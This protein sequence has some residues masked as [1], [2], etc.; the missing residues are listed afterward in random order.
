MASLL[1]LVGLIALLACLLLATSAPVSGQT[2]S[3]SVFFQTFPACSLAV[4]GQG[5]VYVALCD[6]TS[7]L[8]FNASFAPVSSSFD[9]QA[10]SVLSAAAANAPKPLYL[11]AMAVTASGLLWLLD[12]NNLQLLLLSSTSAA[13]G[14]T[15]FNLTA[16]L[17]GTKLAIAPGSDNVWVLLQGQTQPLALYS[18]QGTVL[19]TLGNATTPYLDDYF[20]LGLATDSAGALYVGGCSPLSAFNYQYGQPSVLG[21]YS[22]YPQNVSHC[23]IRKFSSTGVYQQSFSLAAGAHYAFFS[24]ITVD[25][26]GTVYAVDG[27]SGHTFEWNATGSLVNI[28]LP[29]FGPAL[30]AAPSGDIIALSS[31]YLS[32]LDLTSRNLTTKSSTPIAGFAFTEALAVAFS[33]DYLTVYVVSANPGPVA[34]FN[35][36]GYFLGFV[37]AGVVF[38]PQN[39]CTDSAGNIYAAD[40]TLKAIIKMSPNGTYLATFKDPAKAFLW[41]L[42]PGVAVDP[43]T[44]NVVVADAFNRRLVIFYPNTTIYTSIAT[45]FNSVSSSPQAVVVTPTGTIIYTD[46]TFLNE[47]DAQGNLIRQFT[48]TLDGYAIYSLAMAP[49]GRLFAAPFLLSAIYEYDPYGALLQTIAGVDAG[50]ET[51]AIAYSPLTQSLYVPDTASNRI[52][53][54]PIPPLPPIVNGP[55][56]YSVFYSTPSH[57]R[58]GRRRAGQRVRQHRRGSSTLLKYDSTFNPVPAWSAQVGALLA[59]AAG[60]LLHRHHHPLLHDRHPATVLLWLNDYAHGQLVA[61][62]NVSSPHVVDIVTLAEYFSTFCNQLAPAGPGD[63]YGRPA[64]ASAAPTTCGRCSLSRRHQLRALHPAGYPLRQTA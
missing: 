52:L 37:G 44:G 15:T 58:R 1:R 24:A 26:A 16:Q 29:S 51:W 33:P 64:T 43:T 4:D 55:V 45:S 46:Q 47:I 61:I 17:G 49:D 32:V 2:P 19:Q 38:Y 39:L 21:S 31:N 7:V 56:G 18:P 54:I 36:S 42:A 8:K 14:V 11:Q 23:D 13:T 60:Q 30:A 5:S 22:F 63:L 12:T 41:L 35:T 34:K 20:T 28:T 40:S 25:A 57:R 6:S 3:Y 59:T 53:S 10:A 50:F 27:Y 48:A 62:N 9:A